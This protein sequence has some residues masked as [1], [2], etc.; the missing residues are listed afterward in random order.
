MLTLPDGSACTLRVESL[1]PQTL[2]MSAPK[3]A[4]WFYPR[5]FTCMTYTLS[6]EPAGRFTLTDCAE[7]DQPLEITP[8]EDAAAAACVGIIG[9]AVGP[10][11]IVFGGKG[12]EGCRAACSAPHFEPVEGAITWRVTV[13]EERFPAITCSLFKR[14][15]SHP[16]RV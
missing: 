5:H 10:T 8:P 7:A 2:P 16:A 1:E 14:E 13:Y 12:A 4:R 9:G 11:A 15:P 6:P 3:A